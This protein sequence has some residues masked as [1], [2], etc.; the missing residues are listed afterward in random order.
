M[1]EPYTCPFWPGTSL[2]GAGSPLPSLPGLSLQLRGEGLLR[3]PT[4][5]DPA[6]VLPEHPVHSVFLVP[7]S[8]RTFFR[9]ALPGLHDVSCKDSGLLDKTEPQSLRLRNLSN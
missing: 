4:L 5:V 9:K 1:H 7:K 2:S 3:P 6:A 8:Q